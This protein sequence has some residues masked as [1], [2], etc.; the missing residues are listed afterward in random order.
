MCRLLLGRVLC[1]LGGLLG[2]VGVSASE[3]EVEQQPALVS[4][5]LQL[6]WHHQFQFAGYYAALAKGYY[7]DVGLDVNFVEAILGRDPVKSVLEGKAEFGVGK[8]DL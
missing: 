7:R 1:V 8:T 6:K 2:L 3:V 4:V 5:N